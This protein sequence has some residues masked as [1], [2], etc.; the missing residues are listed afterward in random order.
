MRLNRINKFTTMEV[1]MRNI[2]VKKAVIKM[3]MIRSKLKRS[4]ITTMT[5]TSRIKLILKEILAILLSIVMNK[6]I[7]TTIKIRENDFNFLLS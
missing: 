3:T 5:T 2:S 1:I 6:K 4:I 7:K